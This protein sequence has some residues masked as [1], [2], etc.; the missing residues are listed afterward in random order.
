MKLDTDDTEK[1]EEATRDQS[2]SEL[3][4]ALR[5]GRLTSS[6]FGEIRN[7]KEMTDSRLVRDIMGYSKQTKTLPPQIC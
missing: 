7:R 3:W 1:I 4:H 2:D 5:N 6:R